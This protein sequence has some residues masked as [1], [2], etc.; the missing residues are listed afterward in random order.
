ME[1]VYV[2]GQPSNIS[3]SV[4]QPG[5]IVVNPPS[6][7]VVNVKT[8]FNVNLVDPDL[9]FSPLVEEFFIAD[10]EGNPVSN[11]E[12]GAA[13]TVNKVRIKI[14]NMSYMDGDLIVQRKINSP[15]FTT[16]F[17]VATI[18]EPSAGWGNQGIDDT[19]THNF[20][21]T[22]NESQNNYIYRLKVRYVVGGSELFVYKNFNI[23]SKTFCRFYSSN[24]PVYSLLTD[25]FDSADFL[26]STGDYENILSYRPPAYVGFLYIL[27]PVDK[28]I[29]E[30]AL[31]S[32]D[33]G[34]SDFTSSFLDFGEFSFTQENGFGFTAF[35]Y[36][37]Y[38]VSQYGAF[39]NK[40]TLR[41]KLI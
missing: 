29:S 39:D 28:Q 27:V 32:S 18:N 23:D 13:L 35:S 8:D 41:I 38:R 11:L 26:D 1:T 12:F 20:S 3:V 5:V 37:M 36:R 15:S 21:W 34:I 30:A 40:R 25:L 16:Y 4:N 9:S 33:F 17:D 2:N 31:S 10:N 6:T 19:F 7:S 14:S 22:S 24:D